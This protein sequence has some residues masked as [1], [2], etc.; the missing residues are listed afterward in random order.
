MIMNLIL[1]GVD[2]P[3]GGI[4]AF[5]KVS[6]SCIRNTLKKMP[7]KQSAS[8]VLPMKMV[9]DEE[10]MCELLTEVVNDSLE[11]GIFPD[12]LKTSIITP[13]LKNIN[14]DT[15]ELAN[16][17]PVCNNSLNAKVLEKIVAVQ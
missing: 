7:M 10:Q 2:Q 6:L 11:S 14:L 8:D 4:S 17:R 12:T 3:T 5:Q 15:D 9:C 13:V 1:N 16:F